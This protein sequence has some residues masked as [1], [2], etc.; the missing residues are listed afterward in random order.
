MGKKKSTRIQESPGFSR[1]ERV[2]ALSEKELQKQRTKI[3]MIF[4]HFNLMP[5]RTA[6]ENIMLPLK[7]SALSKDQCRKKALELMDLVGLADKAQSYPSQLSGGQK[8]RVAIARALA[9]DPSVLLCDEATSALDPQTTNSILSLIRDL[10]EKLK[11]T[12]VI[13][14]HQMEV[15]KNI[16][17]RAAVMEQGK[18]V[19]TGAVFELFNHPRQM[20]TR[21]F[22]ENATTLG[23]FNALFK[24]GALPGMTADSP[25]WFLTFTGHNTGEALT[26]QLSKLFNVE[27]NIVYGNI[28]FIKGEV[29]GKLALSLNGTPEAIGKARAFLLEHGVEV[30][31]LKK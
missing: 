11:L 3:G 15:V 23:S 22:I 31:E 9:N 30:T 20:I 17:D 27:A 6:L 13:I 21:S 7:K 2:K 25:V 24:A 14:T 28:D 29:L 4:Q 18:V 5:S 12:V 16:C 19:E 10:N 8:Q 26:S 1:G